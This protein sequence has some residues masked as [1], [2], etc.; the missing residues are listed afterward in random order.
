MQR[1]RLHTTI[2]NIAFVTMT[3]YYRILDQENEVDEAFLPELWVESPITGACQN[4][5][6]DLK[7]LGVLYKKK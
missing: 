2:K 7:Y 5:S 1:A 6:K 3:I 4:R